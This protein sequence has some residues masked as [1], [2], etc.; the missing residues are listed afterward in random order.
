MLHFDSD[1]MEGCCPEILSR[2]QEINLDKTPGYGEDRFCRSAAEKI[3]LSCGCPTAAVR[4]LVGGTQTNKVVIDALLRPWEGVIAG[5]SGHIATHEAGAVERCGHKVL[6]IPAVNGLLRA[7]DVAAYME[8]FLADE[9][10]PHMVQPGMVYISHPSEYGTLYTRQD[11]TELREV[12]DRFALK[13]YLDGARLGYGLAAHGS[14]VTLHHIARLTDVFYIGGTKVGALFGEAVVAPR[15]ETLGGAFTTLIKQNGALLAKGWLLGL[16]FDVLFTEG[17]YTR[18]AHR[19]IDTA[20]RLRQGLIARGIPL[21]IDSPTN[22]IFPIL[23]NDTLARLRCQ[24]GFSVWEK[25]DETHTVVRFV[26]SW[27]TTPE[28]VD[29]LLD[30]L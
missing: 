6:P 7:V 23:D 5:D 18:I 21:Y 25:A 9:T 13:L 10:H 1:Y 22:Q 2:L 14:D 16:Q 8:R 17:L 3:R 19:A 27:A 12:C 24:A 11:L 4:F 15:P 26:T 29:A 28:A 20:A 30:L